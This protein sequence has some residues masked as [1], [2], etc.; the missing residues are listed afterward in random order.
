MNHAASKFLLPLGILSTFSLVA[1]DDDYSRNNQFGILAEAVFLKRT[2]GQN[3]TLAVDSSLVDPDVAG[4]GKV[5][6][7]DSLISRFSYEPGF[8]VGLSYIYDR[9]SSFESNFML[10]NEWK[11]Q[12]TAAGDGTL[13]FPFRETYYTNDYVDADVA[14]AKYSSRLYST[15]YN[16]WRGITPRYENY[17]G[18]S[19][20]VGLR[21][22]DLREHFNLA[23]TKTVDEMLQT[24]NYKI[25]TKN[26]MI[27]AQA[28]ADLQWNATKTL[29]WDF[30]LKL[31][32]F[33]NLGEQST[34][35]RDNNNTTTIRKFQTNATAASSMLEGGL[36]LSY[37]ILDCINIHTGFELLFLGGLALAPDQIDKNTAAAETSR[38][39]FK[40]DPLFYGFYVGV[41]GSF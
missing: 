13:Y 11:S 12:K 21:Y 34:S 26:R 29:S 8:R 10:I 25:G 7:S 15:E 3:E 32:G 38:L 33:F 22:I 4:S 19:F 16:Y 27:G 41:V 9:K 5:L 1:D 20:I 39:K 14:T 31:G 30:F 35:L 6:D 2:K 24:S 36:S 23:Y 28:G 18:F 37:Q 17:F 40:G